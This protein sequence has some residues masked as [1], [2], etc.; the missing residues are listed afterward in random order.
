MAPDI[1]HDRISALPIPLIPIE[2]DGAF[3]FEQLR[4]HVESDG[5]LIPEGAFDAC[6][7]LL[8]RVEEA[9]GRTADAFV[10]THHPLTVF[11]LSYQDGLIHGLQRIRKRRKSGEYHCRGHVTQRVGGYEKRASYYRRKRDYWNSSY[12]DGYGDAMLYLLLVIEKPNIKP[13]LFGRFGDIDFGS[14]SALLRFPKGKIKA[15]YRAQAD[16]IF[17]SLANEVNAYVPDHT[18]YL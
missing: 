13:L 16:S 12:S 9:H 8:S 6:L 7:D 17:S 11:A 4:L 3:F 5:D 18:P 10:Q 14:L 2:T 15:S 1:D